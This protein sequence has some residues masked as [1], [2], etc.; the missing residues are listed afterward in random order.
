MVSVYVCV[1]MS[2]YLSVCLCMSVCMP[3]CVPVCRDTVWSTLEARWVEESL[4]PWS[5]CMSVSV[6]LCVCLYVYVCL[7]VCLCVC[8]SVEILFGVPWKHVGLKSSSRRGGSGGSGQVITYAVTLVLRRH[9]HR[10][11]DT[12]DLTAATVKV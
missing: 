5:L 3:L 9:C 4:P 6:C 1:S 11:V 12:H 10:L 2:V 8:L 7:C